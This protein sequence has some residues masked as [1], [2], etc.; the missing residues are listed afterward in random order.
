MLGAAAEEQVAEVE[1]ERLKTRGAEEV[2]SRGAGAD[3]M[4]VWWVIEGLPRVRVRNNCTVV[5][6]RSP[7][8]LRR[9]F[10]L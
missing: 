8:P 2:G 4:S 1:E 5:F 3:G 9:F 6:H 7:T 10:F